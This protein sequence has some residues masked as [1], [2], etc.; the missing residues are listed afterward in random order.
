MTKTVCPWIWGLVKNRVKSYKDYGRNVCK[1]AIMLIW[2]IEVNLKIES[3]NMLMYNLEFL[4]DKSR[5]LFIR[6]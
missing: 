5:K 1:Q 6:Q 3:M 4:A 2:L